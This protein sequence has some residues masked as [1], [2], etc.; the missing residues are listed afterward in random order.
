[1]FRDN[2]TVIDS[3]TIPYAKLHKHH[4]ALSFQW[5]HKA[6]AAKVLAIYHLYSEYYN[7]T[8]ILSKALGSCTSRFGAAFSSQSCFTSQGDTA[9]LY[10]E[11]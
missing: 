11:H 2:Q 4:N 6:V 8:K 10:Y 1:M 3:S 5:I 7:P 9:E